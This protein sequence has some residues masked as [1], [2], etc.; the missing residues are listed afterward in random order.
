[1]EV[2]IMSEKKGKLRRE[3]RK[4]VDTK[5]ENAIAQIAKA[6]NITVENLLKNH[7]RLKEIAYE[8]VR[9]K[10]PSFNQWAKDNGF[11]DAVLEANLMA[12]PKKVTRPKTTKSAAEKKKKK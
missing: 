5:A 11:E 10:L 8:L 1:M 7:P 2:L 6:N 4:L 3:H 12:K 9:V